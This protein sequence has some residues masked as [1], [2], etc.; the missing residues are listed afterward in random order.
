M[1]R[2]RGSIAVYGILGIIASFYIGW[3]LGFPIIPLMGHPDIHSLSP[4]TTTK[5]E[6]YSASLPALL[7][8]K[9]Y[10]SKHRGFK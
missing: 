5:L 1:G 7:T 3:P 6:K 4:Y 8:L 2:R 10:K 9:R